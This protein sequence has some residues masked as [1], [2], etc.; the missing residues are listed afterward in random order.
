[1][2]TQGV[3]KTF[4]PHT[5]VGVI[6]CEDGSDEVFLRTESLEGSIFRFLRQGQRVVFDVVEEAGQSY[7]SAVRVGHEGY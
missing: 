7:A 6:A 3:V 4:D 1:M 5:G 2:A